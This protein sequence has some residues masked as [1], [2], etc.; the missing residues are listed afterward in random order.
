MWYLIKV[1]RGDGKDPVEQETRV[2]PI[3]DSPEAMQ[4]CAAK[5]FDRMP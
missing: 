4:I 5:I 1:M 2:I 3:R